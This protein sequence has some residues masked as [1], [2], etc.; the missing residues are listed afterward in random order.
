MSS[1]SVIQTKVQPNQKSSAAFGSSEQFKDGQFHNVK[2]ME[3]MS[4]SKIPGYIKRYMTEDRVDIEPV[5]P[6]PV[7]AIT[8]QALAQLPSDSITLIRL[9]HSSFLLKA[10]DDYWLI[11]PVFSDRASPFSFIGP[12]RFHQPPITIDALPSIKGVIISHNHYDH[13][14]KNAVKQLAAKVEKFIVPLGI[15]NDLQN[16][17]VPQ[18]NITELDWWQT[19]QVGGLSLTATP[20]QHFSGRSLTDGNTTLWSSW[21]MKTEDHA[22]FY[23]GDSGYFDGFKQIGEKYGPFDMTIIETGAYDSEWPDVHMTPE[24][25]LQAHIDV[26]GAKML[27]AHNG[28]FDLAFHAWYEP[29]ERITDLAQSSGVDLVTPVVGEPVDIISA[30]SREAWWRGLN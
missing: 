21:V 19:T 14:D 1:C 17:G 5:K 28:T 20:A 10:A 12:K 2:A 27:P 24:Q 30:D 7:R 13:L 23:S 22:L 26:K 29:L 4:L 11:D 9:G 15:G 25:S 8:A 3:P 16:W 18:G 6:I